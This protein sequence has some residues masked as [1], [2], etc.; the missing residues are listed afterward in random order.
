M[1]ILKPHGDPDSVETHWYAFDRRD[2]SKTNYASVQWT[3][4]KGDLIYWL[5][6]GSR[7]AEVSRGDLEELR[8]ALDALLEVQ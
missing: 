4:H 5:N 2:P 6:V 3:R 8:T 1:P 7:T